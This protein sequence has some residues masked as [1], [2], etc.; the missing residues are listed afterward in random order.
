M[1][2][3]WLVMMT[4]G[5]AL[6]AAGCSSE[7]IYWCQ[8]QNCGKK[9][10][11]TDCRDCCEFYCRPYHEAHCEDEF[12]SCVDDVSAFAFIQRVRER[13][14]ISM[15]DSAYGFWLT[16]YIFFLFFYML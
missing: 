15:H 8:E 2:I 10:S 4:A 9:N 14:C 13:V 7:N 6:V 1:K 3:L 12:D 16:K 11:P 5:P